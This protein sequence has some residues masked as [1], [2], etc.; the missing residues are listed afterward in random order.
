[1]SWGALGEDGGVGEYERSVVALMARRRRRTNFGIAV[2]THTGGYPKKTPDGWAL[3]AWDGRIVGYGTQTG[4][5]KIRPPQRGAWI[6]STRCS[7]R[8]RV[9]GQLYSCRG[10]GEGVAAN[11]RI[12]KNPERATGRRR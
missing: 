8:F 9:H 3:T 7:Y 1:M 11:C 10:Y 12:I 2:P 5:T 4:C 6:S